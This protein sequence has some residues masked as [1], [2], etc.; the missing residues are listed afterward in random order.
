MANP[1]NASVIEEFK[2][3]ER[4]DRAEAIL[5]HCK[6]DAYLDSLVGT[7]GAEDL[8]LRSDKA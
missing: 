6:T 5:A 2:H 4:L 3:D 8:S 1:L 7:L